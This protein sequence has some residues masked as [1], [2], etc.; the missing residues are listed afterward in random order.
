MEINQIDIEAI[1]K[2]VMAS[3]AKPE[4]SCK[5][6]SEVPKQARVSML[7]EKRK[8]E[9]KLSTFQRLQKTKYLFI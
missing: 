5:T 9:V 8:L 6:S 4:G 3:M 2:N 7:T 1:V